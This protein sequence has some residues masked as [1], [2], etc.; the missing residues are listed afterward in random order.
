ML[1][2]IYTSCTLK[3]KTKRFLDKLIRAIEFNFISQHKT[4][5]ILIA[6]RA[7]LRR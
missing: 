2:N 4:D 6:I 3:L 7:A 1:N 5:I